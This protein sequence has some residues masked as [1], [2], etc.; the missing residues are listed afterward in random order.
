M[1]ATELVALATMNNVQWEMPW[2]ILLLQKPLNDAIKF[3][4]SHEAN[5]GS[6]VRQD[7][8][9]GPNFSFMSYIRYY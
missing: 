2:S 3:A 8:H 9:T 1:K 4:S 6:S 5:E 7:Y